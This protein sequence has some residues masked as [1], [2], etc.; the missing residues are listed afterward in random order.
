MKPKST[1]EV[2]LGLTR[3]GEDWLVGRRRTSDRLDGL[4][5]F[6]G[7]KIRPG[8]SPSEAAVRECNEELGVLVDP[9]GMLE[10]VEHDYGD[11]AV[12]LHPVLCEWVRGEPWA[13]AA[14]VAEVRWVH[15]SALAKLEM[16]EAN[17]AIVA[18]LS[19]PHE[20]T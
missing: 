18:V 13:R 12:R 20:P 3:R 7:G 6:P 19:R 9:I 2:A 16:P 1:V 15:R 5:E 4:W 17:G 14:A 10:V 11:Y 8:E